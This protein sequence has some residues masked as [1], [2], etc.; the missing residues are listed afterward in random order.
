MATLFKQKNISKTNNYLELL[1][2]IEEHKK[3]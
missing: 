3:L 1:P 2:Q